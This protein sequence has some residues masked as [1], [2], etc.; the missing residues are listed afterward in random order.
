MRS[1]TVFLVVMLASACSDAVPLGRAGACFSAEADDPDLADVGERNE[2]REGVRLVPAGEE[3]GP[4]E[5][6]ATCARG[7]PVYGEFLD[8]AGARFWLAVEAWYGATELIPRDILS[9]VRDATV[10]VHQARGWNNADTVLLSN[11][12][13]PLL[14]LQ[15]AD[16]LRTDAG[17]LRVEDAGGNALPSWN[18]CGSATTHALRFVDDDTAQLAAN[19]QTVQ[20][21]V[22]GV[23]FLATN[24]FSIEHNVQGCEDGPGPGAHVTWVASD[25]SL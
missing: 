22:G 14:A 9:L 12:T 16:A 2:A 4:P 7:M 20:M 15:N 6:F 25:N 1:R 24:I 3:Q 13:Q 18:S 8:G 23:E 5:V 10:E 19:G 11:G 17:A 21:I